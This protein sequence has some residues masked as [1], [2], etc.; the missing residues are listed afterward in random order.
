MANSASSFNQKHLVVERPTRSTNSEFS[1]RF[2]QNV[3][4][5]QKQLKPKVVIQ[6]NVAGFLKL[7]SVYIH[8][9]L[10]VLLSFLFA[11]AGCANRKN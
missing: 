9:L 10:P 8:M 1:I 4:G 6:K 7:E 3:Q 2:H 5:G 11:I